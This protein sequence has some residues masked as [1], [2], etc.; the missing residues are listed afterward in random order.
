MP[1]NMLSI[2]TTFVWADGVVSSNGFPCVAHPSEI[3]CE[4]P[5]TYVYI[6]ARVPQLICADT[7]SCERGQPSGVDLHQT[8]VPTP[9]GIFVQGACFTARLLC[10]YCPEQH[11]GHPKPLSR[12]VKTMRMQGL[13][14]THCDDEAAYPK[15]FTCVDRHLIVS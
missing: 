15:P 13:D 9:I 8:H 10:G 4:Y 3:A 6:D 14:T 7:V 2:S 5:S 11:G 1:L 12:F